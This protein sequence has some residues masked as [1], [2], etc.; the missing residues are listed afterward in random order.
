MLN[1]HEA[2]NPTE[3]ILNRVSQLFDISLA[4]LQSNRRDARITRARQIAIYLIKELTELS[5]TDIGRCL[6]QRSH[7]A[8]HYSLQ[9]ISSKLPKDRILSQQIE[10]LKSELS[11]EQHEQP[12]LIPRPIKV[13]L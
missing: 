5:L 12:T 10:S 13:R 9:Q 4:D 6:G 11:L 7:S 8:I 3:R 2:P 1:G